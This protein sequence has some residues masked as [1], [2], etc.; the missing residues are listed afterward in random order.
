MLND[1]N[2]MIVEDEALIALDLTMTL[3]EEGA[4]VVGPCGTV[5]TA[6]AQVAGAD[7]AILDVDLRGESVYPVADRLKEGGKPFIFHTGRRDLD[8]LRARYGDVPIL[9][10]PSS[11]ESLVDSLARL[12]V[13]G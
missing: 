13:R 11:P 1:L 5:A 10:K 12:M 4:G 2:V 3:E 9:S 8:I 6:M 7:I